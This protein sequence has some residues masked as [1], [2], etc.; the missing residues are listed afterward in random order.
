MSGVLE[1][2]KAGIHASIQGNYRYGYFGQGIPP[3]GPMDEFSHHLGNILVG[4][5]PEAPSLEFALYGGRLKFVKNTVFALA[6]AEF[7]AKL[8]GEPLVS[9]QTYPAKAG[10]I[11]DLG[12]AQNGCRGYLSIA[13]GF[14]VP[15][16]LGSTSTYPP[17]SIGG[18]RGRFLI[19]GDVLADDDSVADYALL[20]NRVFRQGKELFPGNESCIYIMEGPQFDH[21]EEDSIAEF[22]EADWITS[23]K[24]NRVG[25]R[26][27]GIT[28]RFKEREKDPDEAK[29]L[30]NI[31]DDGIPIGGMQTPSGKEIICMAK[32]CVSAGGYT[33]IG[34]AVKASL[35]T[36]GQLAPGRKIKFKLVT[37]DEAIAMKEAKTA[38]YTEAAIGKK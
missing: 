27:D 37:L 8:S 34:V 5:K 21:Y 19:A 29:H 11:L 26:F 17:G 35:D 12:Y 18:Y 6:G 36:L 30:S 2:I 13:G 38:Y 33:K 22:L 14:N 9:W 23:D 31:I 15:L 25:V 32:D 1:V 28:L 16:V 10:D 24:I 7:S 20:E 3:S 4:N